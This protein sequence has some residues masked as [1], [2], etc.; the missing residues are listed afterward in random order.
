MKIKVAIVE[1]DKTYLDRIVMVFTN[2]LSDKIEIY[3]FTD[4]NLAVKTLEDTKIDV[5]LVSEA[6]HI[7]PDELPYACGFAYLVE[8][9]DVDSYN[10]QRTICK[11]QKA[12][13]IYKQIL[14]IFSE[15]VT[16]VTGLRID[17]N[18]SVRVVGFV[19]PTGGVGCSTM[20]AATAIRATK[21]GK[22]VLYLNFDP[23]S[24]ADDFF[25]AEGQ[26]CFSDAIYAVKSRK[27]N[28]ALKLE[29]SVRQD[30]SGVYF[31]ASAKSALDV[32]ELTYEDCTYLLDVVRATGNYDEII[33]DM[34]LSLD[35]DTVMFLNTMHQVVFVSDGTVIA[36][37]KLQRCYHALTIMESQLN[38]RMLMKSGVL[39]NK[40]SNKRCA[41]LTG[42]EMSELGGMPRIEGATTEQIV[43]QISMT[44]VLDKIC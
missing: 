26:A 39:Y 10:G 36:N 2:K 21:L 5:M 3:S 29:S 19:S 31:Y 24:A 6:F 20:A 34:K 43:Q 27:A 40:F 32:Q 12:D 28:T 17:E 7:D 37:E 14:N 9:M 44:D 25:H 23:L 30:V 11:Y 33:V 35:K 42:L 38:I 41:V 1:Q 18:D 16:A 15:N 4:L 13:L 22:R 8:T